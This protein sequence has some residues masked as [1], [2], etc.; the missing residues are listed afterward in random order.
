MEH[1]VVRAPHTERPRSAAKGKQR[2]KRCASDSSLLD[3]APERANITSEEHKRVKKISITDSVSDQASTAP[4]ESAASHG[5]SQRYTR[6][7]RRKTRPERYDPSSTVI[8]KRGE[9]AHRHHKSE[10]KRARRKSRR[11]KGKD[12]ATDIAQSFHAKNVYGDRL[13][14]ECCDVCSGLEGR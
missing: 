9:H 13:T 3:I 5:S 12:P 11:V 10:S 2:P 6:K 8:K 1:G 7:P 4:S 14:V